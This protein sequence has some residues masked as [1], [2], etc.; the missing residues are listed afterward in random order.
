MG[1]AF[2][3]PEPLRR[4]PAGSADAVAVAV[5]LATAIAD[6]AAAAG[7]HPRPDQPALS[8]ALLGAQ[9]IPLLGRQRWPGAA[10][11]VV[12]A[13][14]AAR[15]WASLPASIGAVS[16][17]IAVYSAGVYGTWRIRAVSRALIGAA[18]AAGM[19]AFLLTTGQHRVT[20]VAVPGIAFG[21]LVFG[22]SQRARRAHATALEERAARLEA[23]QAGQARAAVTAE[24]A[25]IAR[26]LHDMVAHQVSAIA[27]HTEAARLLISSRPDQATQSLDAIKQASD[28]A[29]SEMHQLLGLLRADTPQVLSPQPG[30][31]QLADLI[32]Q[33]HASGL[34]VAL[35]S[36]EPPSGVPAMVSL[37][38]YRIIQEAL[39]NVRKHA[40]RTTARVT[41]RYYPAFVD[42]EVTD[43]GRGPAAL[44]CP[45]SGSG[46]AGM[47]ERA[48]LCHGT[49]SAGPRPGGGYR[50]RAR[51]PLAQETP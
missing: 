37:H 4:L 17:I 6:P 39:T 40:G 3:P 15:L 31:R 22:D 10:L 12:V 21:A 5:L 49:F 45:G 1:P 30:L 16:L 20:A 46:L 7:D 47:Q 18:F 38:A 28:Q 24:R 26:E 25:R 14:T 27:L 8:L 41:V 50:V 32:A 9:T 48:A 51:L 29:L 11:T 35:A 13:A 42:V 19:L 33:S 2:S 44:A 43:D 34:Q 36:D 23:D